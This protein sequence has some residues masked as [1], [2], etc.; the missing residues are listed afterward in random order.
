MGGET[1]QGNMGQEHSLVVSHL[2]G[3]LEF[4]GISLASQDLGRS[5]G[6]AQRGK[7][8]HPDARSCPGDTDPLLSKEPV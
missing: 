2:F 7:H 1:S 5:T 3:D 6:N 4:A 8:K